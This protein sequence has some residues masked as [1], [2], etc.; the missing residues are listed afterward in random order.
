MANQKKEEWT[1]KNGEGRAINIFLFLYVDEHVML[2]HIQGWNGRIGI[3]FFPF[4]S[5]IFFV[6]NI[7]IIHAI[8]EFQKGKER[9]RGEW[10]ERKQSK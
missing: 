6:I 8:L 3:Q 10:G 4:Q 7:L 2:F 1:V 9:E 5:Y